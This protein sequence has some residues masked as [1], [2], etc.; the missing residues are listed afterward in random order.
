MGEAGKNQ[1]V[2]EG[3]GQV[4]QSI[5]RNRDMVALKNNNDAKKTLFIIVKPTSGSS[6]KNFVDIMDELRIAK[7][8]AA[9]AIDDDHITA[10]E[11]HFLKAHKIF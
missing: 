9:P 5:I 7:I 2:I 11:Q 10:E 1:P 3:F 4:R 8:T 6:Y